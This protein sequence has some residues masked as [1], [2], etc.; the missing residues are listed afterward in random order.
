LRAFRFIIVAVVALLGSAAIYNNLPD[1]RYRLT[2]EI[3]TPNGVKSGS[4]VIE[5]YVGDVRWGLP[6][7]KGLRSRINGEAVFVD[8]G[9]GRNVIGILAHGGAAERSER[10]NFLVLEAYA[11]HGRKIQW[12]EMKNMNGVVDLN[13]DLVPTLVSFSNINDPR[14]A[15]VIYATER[16]EVRDEQGRFLRN[17]PKIVV[18]DVATVLGP[19]YLF[20]RAYVEVTR[21]KKTS[22]IEGR[23]PWIKTFQGYLG[24]EFDASRSRP[25]RNLTGNEFKR[26]Y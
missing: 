1:H 20:K 7:A 3:D 6:E 25:S 16:I 2:I 4:S 22:T 10:M 17:E 14:T 18:D 9:S 19:G 8:L 23:L 12:F 13:G 5:V 15:H 21:D 24:G 26:D 11:S